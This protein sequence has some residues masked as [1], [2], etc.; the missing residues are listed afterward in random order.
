MLTLGEV[1]TLSDAVHTG[2]REARDVRKL[3]A[4]LIKR[5]AGHLYGIGGREDLEFEGSPENLLNLTRLAARAHVVT[6]AANRPRFLPTTHNPSLRGFAN[7]LGRALDTHSKR[8]NLELTLQRCV[9]DAFFGLGIA[10]VF[11]ADMLAVE[12][13]SQEWMGVGIPYVGRISLDHFAWDMT[14]PSFEEA[15]FLADRYRVRYQD[16]ITDEAIEPRVRKKLKRS[17]PQEI[18]SAYEEAHAEKLVRPAPNDSAQFED[19]LYLADVFVARDQKIYT[20]AVDENFEFTC[21]EPLKIN[22]WEGKDTGN[23]SFLGFGWVPDNTRISSPA[24]NI[25]AL[26]DM[27]NSSYRK[28]ADQAKRQKNIFVG[29]QSGEDDVVEK[30]RMAEDGTYFKSDQEIKEVRHD[31]PNQ[32]VMVL[33]QQLL[34]HFNTASGNVIHKLGLG[35]QADT[36]KQEAMIGQQSAAADAHDQLEYVRFVREIAVELGSLLWNDNATRIETPLPVPG[37]PFVTKD[38][39]GGAVSDGRN[40]QHLAEIEIDIDPYSMRYMAPEQRASMLSQTVAELTQIAPLISASGGDVR[41]FVKKISEYR[42]M[43]ELTEVFP[44]N[45]PPELAMMLQGG[46]AQ[47]NGGEYIHKS[48]SSP[49]QASMENQQMQTLMAGMSSQN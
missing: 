39:W 41:A 22:D 42:N 40:P 28:L 31:G 12:M 38:I 6:L 9:L 34:Q 45:P 3:R 43:P 4:E 44:V 24:A 18:F 47:Q 15:S 19:W 14:A 35:A 48:Q 46:G 25:S 49:S 7:K 20:F 32:G 30:W 10:K 26:D 5:H 16:V 2:Y 36:A 11:M 29:P 37:T 21:E 8:I 1:Q 23:Y 13:E 17:G 33:A 27:I